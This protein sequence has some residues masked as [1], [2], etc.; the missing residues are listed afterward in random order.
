LKASEAAPLRSLVDPDDPAFL[1]PADMVE[2][3][4][5]ACRARGEPIPE[6]EGQLVRCVLESLALRYRQVVTWLEEITGTPI[7]VIHIVGGGSRNALL[8]QF[9]ANACNRLVIAGPVE[10]TA[11]GNVLWQAR[12]SGE[13][14]SLADARAVVRA[15]CGA[16]IREFE[17]QRE[18]LALWESAHARWTLPV[19]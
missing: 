15:S 7:E 16:E 4:Q 9:T 5:S 10:T 18:N 11:L 13:I 19:V 1:R 17:P 2:A 14:A 12:S 8:N 3:V 6:T